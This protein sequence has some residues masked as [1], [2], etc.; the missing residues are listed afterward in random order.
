MIVLGIDPSGGDNVGLAVID[1]SGRR[2]RWVL[3]GKCEARTMLSVAPFG[4]LDLVAIEVP[5]VGPRQAA[6]AVLATAAEAGRIR[7]ICEAAGLRVVEC[8]PI[9]W[10]RA[11]VGRTR[12]CGQL[13]IDA[14]TKRA[15]EMRVDGMPKRTSSH[16][17][18]AVGIALFGAEV[19]M[20]EAA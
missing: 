15:V 12:R 3:G 17:R 2:P 9:D 8:Y 6:K 14:M 16:V 20:R 11:I 1:T 4:P 5:S 19:A 10:R 18:D 7:G 13:T